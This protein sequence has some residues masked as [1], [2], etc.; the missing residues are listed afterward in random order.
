MSHLEVYIVLFA[1]IISVGMLFGKSS[2]PLPLLLVIAGMLIALLPGLPEV[3][4]DPELIL[5]IFLPLLIFEI[6]TFTSW[7]DVKKN[8]RPIAM[9]SVGHVVFITL[10]VAIIVHS[11]IPGFNWPMAFLLGAIVSPPD[12]VALVSIAEQ[13]DLPQRIITILKGEGMLNDAAA[14]TLFRF[15]LAAIFTHQF[16][17]VSAVSSFFIIIVA[18]T[19]YGFV[20]GHLIGKLSLKINNPILQIM[21]SLLTPFLA[22]LPAQ[23]LGG[24]GVLAT[25]VTGLIIG[26]KYMERFQ[27]EVRIIGHSVWVMLSFALQS[28]L[29]LLVGLDLDTIW[30]H[31]SFLPINSLVLYSLALIVTVII[32]RFLWVYPAT[33]LSRLIPSIRKKDPLPPWQYPFIVSWLGMRGGI[34]L[35]AALAVPYL[36]NIVHQKHPRDLI[37]FLVFTVIMATLILQG[38]AAPFIIRRLGIHAHV[39]HEKYQE[40]LAELSARAEIAKAVLHWL[41]EYKKLVTGDK[42]LLEEVKFR[43]KEYKALKIQMEQSIKDHGDSH[44]ANH[45]EEIELRDTIF[46]SEKIVEVERT[47][48]ARLWHEKK[49]T[50]SLKNKLMRQLDHR[51]KHL[52]D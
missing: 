8:L 5:N 40:H 51:S 36:A 19:V 10:L 11:F 45:N 9:L 27:P 30:D 52:M 46:L 13:V 31:I 44:A 14:L 28:I 22:Y 18:E 26:H 1:L 41:S 33:Y 42:Q 3:Q 21:L 2:I 39:K 20:L 47:E 48:L 50:H 17:L 35:A 16:S 25:V 34:S 37:V 15:S 6:S 12:D 38:L 24:S 32:G 7:R 4:L 29:F 49:I 43:M 23:R